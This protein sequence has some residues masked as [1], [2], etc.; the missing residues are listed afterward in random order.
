LRRWSGYFQA[1]FSFL[2]YRK[3]GRCCYFSHRE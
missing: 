3:S 2:R 1:Y